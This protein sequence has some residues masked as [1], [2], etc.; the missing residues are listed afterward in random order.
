MH[1][2]SATH[3][4][5]HGRVNADMQPGEK[6][7]TTYSPYFSSAYLTRVSLPTSDDYPPTTHLVC[8]VP[9]APKVTLMHHVFATDRSNTV[10]FRAVA[11]T[12]PFERKRIKAT[13]C[14][15]AM[16]YWSIPYKPNRSAI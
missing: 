7:Q 5:D 4:T 13:G 15:G 11:L 2:K 9:S 1:D 16:S 14:L 8:T 10:F 12:K 6:A 3:H